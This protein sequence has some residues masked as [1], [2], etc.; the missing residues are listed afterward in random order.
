MTE[1]QTDQQIQQVIEH[2]GWNADSLASLHQDFIKTR[3][4]GRQWLDH[5]R[6][7]AATENGISSVASAFTGIQGPWAKVAELARTAR[8]VRFD[9]CHNIYLLMD[10]QALREEI[11]GYCID[12]EDAQALLEAGDVKPVVHQIRRGQEY[13]AVI[14]AGGSP[15]WIMDTV[16]TSWEASCPLRMVDAVEG[17]QITGVV[18]QFETTDPPTRTR[19]IDA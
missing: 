3:N 18:E 14:S 15:A 12:E 1:N 13:T 17:D 6:D 2:Q 4:L 5:L 7:A 8:G 10:T 19:Q 16:I 11:E 9:G